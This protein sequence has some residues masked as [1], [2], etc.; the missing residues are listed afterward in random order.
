MTCGDLL[1]LLA[2]RT[3]LERLLAETPAE[4]VLDRASLQARK[5]V[6]EAAIVKADQGGGMSF[7]DVGQVGRPP[8][9]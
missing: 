2:E 7:T 9:V 1:H 8:S 3:A 4:D 6:V 5:Q